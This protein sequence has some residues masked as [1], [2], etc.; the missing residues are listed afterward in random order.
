[1]GISTQTGDGQAEKTEE[2]K[3]ET[4]AEEKNL[5]ETIFWKTWRQGSF[6]KCAGWGGLAL[7]T[8]LVSVLSH[9]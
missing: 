3:E 6:Q 7:P 9:Y 2:K 5:V 8:H 1:M 4:K